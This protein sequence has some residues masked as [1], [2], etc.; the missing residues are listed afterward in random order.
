MSQDGFVP[1]M[2]GGKSHDFIFP[3]RGNMEGFVRHILSGQEYELP[4]PPYWEP[5]V[6]V[7]IGANVGAFSIYCQSRFPGI[8]VHAFEPMAE[9]FSYA[10]RNF[11]PFPS[12]KARHLGLSDRDVQ[13]VLYHGRDRPSQSSLIAA[14]QCATTTEAVTLVDAASILERL[15]ITTISI[16]KVDTE[17]CEV[18]ILSRLVPWLPST[19]LVHL[20]YH[21]DNDRRVL[22]QIMADAGHI[23]WRARAVRP[24]V[25][26][27]AY[28]S[29]SMAS[30]LIDECR[31]AI[32]HE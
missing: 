24:H 9:A 6:V 16:L 19:D 14:P 25:G 13:A 28:I 27:A 8:K 17:G 32:S 18:P 11:A 3:A 1:V 26:N 7:D 10:E 2:L 22:D 4:S 31:F 23:L 12:M 29:R 30:L 5:K 20:E 21:N 15:E